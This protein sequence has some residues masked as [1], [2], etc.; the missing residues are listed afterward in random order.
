MKNRPNAKKKKKKKKGQKKKKKKK[1]K[2][3]GKLISGVMIYR[4]IAS[5]PY[6]PNHFAPNSY[7]PAE[8][9]SALTKNHI[10]PTEIH[11]APTYMYIHIADSP[12]ANMCYFCLYF[13]DN[14]FQFIHS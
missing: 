2:I 12:H 1:K 8:I 7:R 10:A 6:R 11:I 9:H 14:S 5:I 3:P 4:Y 13:A